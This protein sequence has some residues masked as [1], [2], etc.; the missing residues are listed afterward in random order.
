LEIAAGGP[1][2]D[3]NDQNRDLKGRPM[4]FKV[5]PEYLTMAATSCDST[6]G[7]IQGQL[8]ALKTYVV[9]MEAYW[10]GIAAGTFQGLMAEYD[11]CS[12]A[13]NDALTGI[14]NGLRGNWGNYTANEQGNLTMINNIQAGLP[15]PNLG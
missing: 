6:A 7:E 5:T 10:G 4:A 12:A 1:E 11:L 8:A 15:S 3:S 2:N 9:N 13:L 14:A